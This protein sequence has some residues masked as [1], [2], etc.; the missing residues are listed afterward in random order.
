MIEDTVLF[1]FAD[2]GGCPKRI[3]CDQS[4]RGGQGQGSQWSSE[5]LHRPTT[6]PE[7]H[8]VQRG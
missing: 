1:R 4:S 5:V 2:R 3:P 8:K 7:R 6:Q